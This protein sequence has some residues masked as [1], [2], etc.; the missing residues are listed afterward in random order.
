MIR[1]RWPPCGGRDTFQTMWH[2]PIAFVTGETGTGKGLVARLV[3]EASGEGPFV[4]VDCAS[5]A[6]SVVESEAWIA[7]FAA[8]R[9]QYRRLRALTAELKESGLLNTAQKAA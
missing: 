4:H 1:E 9:R 7:Y 6:P 8:F 2:V 3:H 5:L